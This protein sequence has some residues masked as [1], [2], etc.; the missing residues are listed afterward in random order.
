MI[1]HSLGSLPSSLPHHSTSAP[2]GSRRQLVSPQITKWFRK[3][4]PRKLVVTPKK[5]SPSHD[6]KSAV[7]GVKRKLCCEPDT[8]DSLGVT[9]LKMSRPSC[10]NDAELSSS[11]STRTV[12]TNLSDTVDVTPLA[13]KHKMSRPSREND[14]KLSPSKPP[15]TDPPTALTVL[16]SV[17]TNCNN[18]LFSKVSNDADVVSVT[19]H[20]SITSSADTAGMS[21]CSPTVNLPN[22]V[23]N[24]Q[25]CAPIGQ[26]LSPVKRRHSRDWLTQLR[27]ERQTIS[28]RSSP[29]TGRGAV[30]SKSTRSSKSS[31]PISRSAASA[32]KA[33]TSKT[34]PVNPEPNAR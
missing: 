2:P 3:S 6:A 19:D 12:S 11:K 18:R 32:I 17:E 8:D 5:S 1:R 28:A 4:T 10:E 34:S 7:G 33:S 9:Q 21:Y 15:R 20:S 29:P 27:L 26:R 16:S 24:P 13:V 14:A 31:P 23:Y 22:Y 25:P 30:K